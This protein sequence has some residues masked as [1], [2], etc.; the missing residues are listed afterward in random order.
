[1]TCFKRLIVI[2]PFFT[3]DRSHRCSEPVRLCGAHAATRRPPN[4]GNPPVLGRDQPEQKRSERSRLRTAGGESKSQ[5]K[6]IWMVFGPTISAFLFLFLFF[7]AM[8][9][10]REVRRP[11][12]EF[13]SAQAPGR[14][15]LGSWARNRRY[16]GPQRMIRMNCKL[17]KTR[18][19]FF[20]H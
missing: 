20:E 18:L 7:S 6:V 19:N 17:W 3:L 14:A 9:E 8:S 4:G 16:Q 15:D 1:M 2:A 12:M 5:R 11:K 13:L 10:L